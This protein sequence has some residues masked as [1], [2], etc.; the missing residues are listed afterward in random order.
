MLNNIFPK[1]TAVKNI[2]FFV[3]AVLFIIFIGKIQDI[4]IL[5]FASYVIAC[6]FN[7]MVDK[8]EKKFKR[9]TSASIVL[10]SFIIL[11][12]A[13]II[14]L[15]Y[16]SANEI[17]SFASVF[18]SYLDSIS[19]FIKNNRYISHLNLSD[20][21][22]GGVISSVTGFTGGF[23]SSSILIGKNI[24]SAFIYLII[25]L[26]IT[27]YFMADKKQV[28]NTC[29]SL[30]PSNMQKKADSIMDAIS[31]KIGGYVIAQTATMSSVGIIMI[32]GLLLIKLDYAVLLGFITA[33]CDIVPVIGP[34][35]ALVIC[36][37]AAYKSGITA[38]VLTIII[39]AIAQLTENNFV[40]PYIF[41]RMLNLHPLIIY[42]FLLIT[43]KYL[44]V[45]GV[46]FAPAIAATVVVLI[47][48]LYI[49]SIK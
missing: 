28:R 35:I 47:E 23:L 29:L 2:I 46:V 18:P 10:F 16:M 43:A 31:V 49:K 11:L 6:S 40:R 32:I 42:L 39:F 22:I 3:I 26:I 33:V 38:I 37:L 41:G 4:A 5:F 21:D 36:L 14:P 1:Y 44:G 8:L 15:I 9:S 13:F 25:S 48:E 24:G 19:D 20:I 17:K 27:F 30:F 45:I 7:P 12:C 34:G